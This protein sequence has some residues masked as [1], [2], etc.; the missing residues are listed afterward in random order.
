MYAAFQSI[1]PAKRIHDTKMRILSDISKYRAGKFAYRAITS[2]TWLC[3][4]PSF[5]LLRKRIRRTVLPTA[6]E[7]RNSASATLTSE[8]KPS[9]A[10]VP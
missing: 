9:A 4:S 3:F 2:A 10:I 5:P 1:S 6:S 7:R 8:A